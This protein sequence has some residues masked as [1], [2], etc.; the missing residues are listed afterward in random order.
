MN[1]DIRRGIIFCSTIAT[2]EIV[3]RNLRAQG[4][5]AEMIHGKLA[6]N[7]RLRIIAGFNKGNP[8]LLVA[9]AVAARGLDIKDVTHIFNYDLPQDPQEYVH[10][11]GRTARAGESGKAITLLSSKDHNTFR[12][13]FNR[14]HVKIEALP[15]ENFPQ[16][17][18]D[19]RRPHRHQYGRR[20]NNHMNKRNSGYGPS[21]H[22]HTR[23]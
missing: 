23:R 9:S 17:P 1:E 18:F 4:I 19:A 8:R 7:K 2:V 13:I 15:D 16:I 21:R 6:Q 10:R 20:N 3:A 22:N 5:Q 11:I 14:C 12:Q